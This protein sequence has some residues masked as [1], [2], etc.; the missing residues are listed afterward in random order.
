MIIRREGKDG[1][2]A[3]QRHRAAGK[4]DARRPRRPRAGN[5]QKQAMDGLGRF[6]GR[7]PHDASEIESCAHGDVLWLQP[8]TAM[9]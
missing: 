5:K 1:R 6:M 8:S 7:Y 2:R 4:P 9:D 3:D